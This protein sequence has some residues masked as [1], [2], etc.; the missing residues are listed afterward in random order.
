MKSAV[1]FIRHRP[2]PLCRR[3]SAPTRRLASSVFPSSDIGLSAPLPDAYS[4]ARGRLLT[5]RLTLQTGPTLTRSVL[6]ASAANPPA[7]SAVVY[8]PGFADAFI[9]THFSDAVTARAIGFFAIDLPSYGRANIGAETAIGSV[10]DVRAIY[11]HIDAVMREVR[12]RGYALVTVVAH[13]YGGLIACDYVKRVTAAPQSDAPRI[14]SLILTAPMFEVRHALPQFIK[15]VVR[16]IIRVAA[17]IVPNAVIPTSITHAVRYKK[18]N[19]APTAATPVRTWPLSSGWYG[20]SLH[21][22]YHGEWKFDTTIKPLRRPPIVVGWINAVLMI[23][24]RIERGQC[25]LPLPILVMHSRSD[26]GGREWNE[27]Y[28]NADAVLNIQDI[29]RL[30]LQLTNADAL[31]TAILTS[32][33]PAATFTRSHNVTL[34]ALSDAL[35]DVFLSN[36]TTRTAAVRIA[37]DFVLQTHE[38]TRK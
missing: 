16:A 24:R 32:D 7:L 15:R 29:R 27:S 11:E 13:S 34:C 21:A 20:R 6:I 2:L 5:Q 31:T 12:R 22:D 33:D 19:F 1:S 35:H 28:T 10:Y 30:A 25:R 23:Q 18:R 14:V 26:G 9:A 38:A 36:K 4:D 3:H 8:V 17:L 37:I